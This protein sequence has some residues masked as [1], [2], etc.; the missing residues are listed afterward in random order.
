MVIGDGFH[1]VTAL[2]VPLQRG[3]GLVLLETINGELLEHAHHVLDLSDFQLQDYNCRIVTFLYLNTNRPPRVVGIC[4]NSEGDDAANIR[5]TSISVDF[6]DV[7]ASSIS[8]F[9]EEIKI[10]LSAPQ[11]ISNFVSYLDLPSCWAGG[12]LNT[13]TFYIDG[14]LGLFDVTDRD[15]NPEGE[16]YDIFYERTARRFTCSSPRLLVRVSD[17]KLVIYCEDGFAEVDICSLSGTGVDVRENGNGVRYYCSG[18]GDMSS[19]VTLTNNTLSFNSTF[20]ITLP[21]RLEEVFVANCIQS[22]SDGQVKFTFTT[23][24]G[25]TYISDLKQDKTI[26]L[27][28]RLRNDPLFAVH[29]VYDEVNLLFS[30]ESTTWLY[31]TSCPNDPWVTSVN[32]SHHLSLY[33]PMNRT[34]HCSCTDVDRDEGQITTTP[35]S[36]QSDIN[37]AAAISCSV[38]AGI[39]AITV[40]TVVFS[41]IG[42]R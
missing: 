11:N 22:F 30:N 23:T 2:L 18:L 34:Q 33:V 26:L 32:H 5:T 1:N 27:G 10:R 31:N 21:L 38:I 3:V 13:L 4:L 29:Q 15:S 25:N 14:N 16:R 20:N 36:T 42:F 6:Q 17:E 41:I 37:I 40:M 8:T 7:L 24:K 12:L 19:L 9:T 39:L 28:R 35:V